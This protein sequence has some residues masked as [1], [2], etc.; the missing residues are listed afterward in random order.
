MVCATTSHSQ[1]A[2]AITQSSHNVA[3]AS[4]LCQLSKQDQL[5]LQRI[6]HVAEKASTRAHKFPVRTKGSFRAAGRMLIDYKVARRLACNRHA[7]PEGF[8]ARDFDAIN[9]THD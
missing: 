7:V 6:L 3:Q 1:R 2:S 5:L 8:L 4:R 9:D